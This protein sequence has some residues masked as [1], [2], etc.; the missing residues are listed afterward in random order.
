LKSTRN[1]PR[2]ERE[3][4]E[5][6]DWYD[7]EQPGLGRELILEIDRVLTLVADGRLPTLPHPTVREVRRVM[8]KRFPF[9]L[10]LLES[11]SEVV[12]VAVAH[13]KRRPEYWLGRLR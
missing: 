13:M 5:A 12:V 9:W 11:E 10:V 3:L 8:L 1:H 6:S 7:K 2:V 4:A